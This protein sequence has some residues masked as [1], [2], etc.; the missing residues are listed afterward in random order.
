[1]SRHLYLLI[2]LLFLLIECSGF[3]AV[4]Q[5]G[6]RQVRFAGYGVFIGDVSCCKIEGNI[7][8]NDDK[9]GIFIYM[10]EGQTFHDNYLLKKKEDD[11]YEEAPR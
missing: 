11:T 1:M 10:D 5:Y 8:E 3:I 9:S 6:H 7:I 4:Y 2:P